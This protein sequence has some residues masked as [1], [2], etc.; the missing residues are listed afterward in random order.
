MNI[1]SYFNI[2]LFL[3]F[4]R[5][6]SGDAFLSNA[7][8]VR[9]LWRPVT[10]SARK[11]MEERS[12][13]FQN[14]HCRNQATCHRECSLRRWCQLWCF[15]EGECVLSRILVSPLYEENEFEEETDDEQERKS[16]NTR[17]TN[18]RKISK[19]NRE[20]ERDTRTKECYTRRSLDFAT[21]AI[22][23]SPSVSRREGR[24]E[25]T[26]SN[27]VDG[28]YNFHTSECYVTPNGAENPNGN[29][30]VIDLKRN[31]PVKKIILYSHANISISNRIR[32]TTIS[33]SSS[34]DK[35]QMRFGNFS[36]FHR[37]GFVKKPLG[38]GAR[39]VVNVLPA[40]L[41]RF[42]MITNPVTNVLEICHLEV[43]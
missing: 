5:A 19:D 9:S 2:C 21:N 35:S 36:D 24:A 30:A 4:T 25:Q 14:F 22:G 39:N 37:V 3:P 28:F 23:Y 11:I 33:V 38:L 18:R 26:I 13:K 1:V 43:M 29:F 6:D 15:N 10:V 27:L 34:F 42:V 41:T 16:R 8:P 7:Y 40:L 20:T 32:H 31:L 12:D 17:S